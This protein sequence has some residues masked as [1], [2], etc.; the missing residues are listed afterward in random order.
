MQR[1]PLGLD[2]VVPIQPSFANRW[3][4]WFAQATRRVP[5]PKS[6]SLL[7]CRVF[8]ARILIFA[9]ALQ[10]KAASGNDR[11]VPTYPATTTNHK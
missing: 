2:L 7:A 6:L 3:S 5:W 9:L 11:S 10:A 4:N 8:A 1:S